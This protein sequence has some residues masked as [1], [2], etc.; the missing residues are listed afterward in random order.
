[1]GAAAAGSG[2]FSTT[3]AG[4]SG[5]FSTTVG[6]GLNQSTMLTVQNKINCTAG[7][8]STTGAG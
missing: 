2:F 6:Y 7:F 1:M 8:F 5:F 3:G 4:A